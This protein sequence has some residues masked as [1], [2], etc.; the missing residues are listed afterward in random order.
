M[1]HKAID[2]PEHLRPYLGVRSDAAIA[3][4][5]GVT[6]TVVGRHRRQ[7]QI[8]AIREIN[9]LP[10]EAIARLGTTS[11]SDLA[12][13]YNVAPQTVSNNCR[14]LGIPKFKPEPMKIPDSCVHLLGK[15]TDLEV[16]K[17]AKIGVSSVSKLRREAGIPQHDLGKARRELSN[18]PDFAVELLGKLPDP[19]IAQQVCCSRIK[20]TNIRVAA[21]I[22]PCPRRRG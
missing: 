19:E 6:A 8:S 21:G 16:A 17:I 22:A 11:D 4:E 10:D 5:M 18:L 1:K 2:I 14:K 3:R 7:N 15:V 20:V 13:E 9:F 12:R